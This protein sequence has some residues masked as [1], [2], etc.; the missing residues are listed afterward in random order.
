[1]PN[2][3]EYNQ[4]YFQKNKY[5]KFYCESCQQNYSIWAKSNHMKTKRHAINQKFR[6]CP[7]LKKARLIELENI[8]NK[9][10]DEFP[11]YCQEIEV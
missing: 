2:T 6:D 11:E 9:I 7:A 1:M 10:K 4:E 3:K 8:L 5:K